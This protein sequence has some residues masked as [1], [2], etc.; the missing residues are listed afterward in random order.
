MRKAPHETSTIGSMGWELKATSSMTRGTPTQRCSARSKAML[1]SIS[2]V[3]EG[4]WSSATLRTMA[5]HP[6]A[7]EERAPGEMIWNIRSASSS[8]TRQHVSNMT[9]HPSACLSWPVQQLPCDGARGLLG[10]RRPRCRRAEP[11]PAARRGAGPGEEQARRSAQLR[12]SPKHSVQRADGGLPR[13]LLVAAALDEVDRDRIPRGRRELREL[14]ALQKG[15]QL[16]QENQVGGLRRFSDAV[17]LQQRETRIQ[18]TTQTSQLHLAPPPLRAL[19]ARAAAAALRPSLGRAAWLGH[20]GGGEGGDENEE[21][22][23]RRLG[24]GRAWI[25]KL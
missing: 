20:R 10:Q 25:L 24:G 16:P 9:K 18:T 12:R 5:G 21:D 17:G 19:R 22:A 2:P 15:D 13:L 11:S 8:P 23:R 3:F 6:A 1:L 7:P 14:P 4:T